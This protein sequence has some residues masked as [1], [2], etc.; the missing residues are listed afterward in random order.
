MNTRTLKL[1]LEYD[2]TN[3]AGWQIQNKGRTIQGV[4]EEA[5]GKI[6][7]HPVRLVAAG[8]TDAGVHAIGQVANFMTTSSMGTERLKRALNG[9]LPRD[10]TVVELD[11]VRDDFNARFDARSRT[12]RYT[13][14]E[15]RLSIGKSYAWHVPYKIDR[16]L[17]VES[18]ACLTGACNLRGFSKGNDEDDYSTVFLNNHWIF[19][20]ALSIFEMTAVRFFH[21][22]VR[23]IVGSAVKVARG[24]ETPDLLLRILETRNRK[25]AGP[26]APAVGLCL[27][28]VDYG[29]QDDVIHEKLEVDNDE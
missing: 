6:L 8:R 19:D 20:G 1:V 9:V 27:I 25:I 16:N 2:G 11:R 23:S 5:V 17:L 22:S 12:Y 3:F 28:A 26:T 29:E 15:R 21:H 13:L 10:I 18:T 4:I 24:K 14:S 7:H